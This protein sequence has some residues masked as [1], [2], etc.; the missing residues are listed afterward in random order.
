MLA[1]SSIRTP[2][3]LAAGPV[4]RDFRTCSRDRSRPRR[5]SYS[6]IVSSS[7]LTMTSPSDPSTTS[8]SPGW[9]AAIKPRTPTT[10]GISRA[11]RMMLACD[12]LP[13][14]SAA[15][16]IMPVRGRCK[17]SIGDRMDPTPIVPG[18]E[19]RSAKT[20]GKPRSVLSRR[21]PMASMSAPRTSPRSR[22][23]PCAPP[24]RR[25]SRRSRSDAGPR[26]RSGRP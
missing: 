12:V 13:P 7:G 25:R 3:R 15:K 14:R 11:F 23:S 10:K 19:A 6:A 16:P 26:P 1:E 8:L 21:S 18:G 22:R 5:S 24:T 17:A 4:T 20:S 2:S 9:T